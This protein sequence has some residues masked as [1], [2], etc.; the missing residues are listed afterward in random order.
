[1]PEQRTISGSSHNKLRGSTKPRVLQQIPTLSQSL[2]TCTVKSYAHALF[3][4]ATHAAR[5]AAQDACTV[6]TKKKKMR[7]GPPAMPEH[8]NK[9]R[10]STK[11]SPKPS[12]RQTQAQTTTSETE[13]DPLR[14]RHMHSQRCR[15]SRNKNKKKRC[16]ADPPINARAAH[17]HSGSSHNT[18]RDSTSQSPAPNQASAKRK[19]SVLHQIPTHSEL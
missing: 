9:L 14:A 1:M 10:G 16:G 8:H 5:E 17:T 13:T 11:P 18:F 15:H 2:D 7:C 3:K 6:K 19:P 4:R 12:H